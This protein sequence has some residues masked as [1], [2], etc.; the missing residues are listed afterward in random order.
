MVELKIY[1]SDN[2]NERFRRAA[3]NVYGYGRGS[4]SK[5]AE[6]ALTEWCIEHGG[7]SKQAD[8]PRAETGRSEQVQPGINPDE[9]RPHTETSAT[10]GGNIV[11]RPVEENHL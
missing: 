3:M 10:I 8:S 2:L 6:E 9:R 11:P 5:A 7:S 1:L 4:L